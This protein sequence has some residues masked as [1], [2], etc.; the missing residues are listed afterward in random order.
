MA[1]TRLLLLLASRGHPG[2]QWNAELAC[3]KAKMRR[4]PALGEG[5]NLSGGLVNK[6]NGPRGVHKVPSFTGF[7]NLL[8]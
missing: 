4:S 8:T 6:R 7:V 5:Y 2:V 3:S 1:T